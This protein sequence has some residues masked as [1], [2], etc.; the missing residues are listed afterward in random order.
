MKVLDNKYLLKYWKYVVTY[1]SHVTLTGMHITNIK[2]ENR[3][4][5]HKLFI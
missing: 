4:N 3:K 5:I 1:R 2:T